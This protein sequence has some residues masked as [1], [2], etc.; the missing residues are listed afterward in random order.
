VGE[1][2]ATQGLLALVVAILATMIYVALRF[3]YRFA[4]SSAFALIHDPILILGV[5]AYFQVGFYL[6]ALAAM[7]AVLGYS[8]NDTIV[9]F[10]RVRE[11]F[12]AMRRSDPLQVMNRSINQTLSRTI[13]TSALTL[14]A[15]LALLFLGGE[16][17]FSFALAMAIG[18]VVGTYSSIYVAGALALAMG[19]KRQDF[20]PAATTEVDGRP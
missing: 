10:D 15:V 9:V 14:V 12:R 8:L 6:P 16:K 2:L 19:L 7:L 3:E 5:F 4:V 17:L 13:M 11:N 1:R 20:L 18:I